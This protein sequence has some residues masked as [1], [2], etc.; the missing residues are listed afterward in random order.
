MFISPFT[1]LQAAT[2]LQLLFST[3]VQQGRNRLII[4]GLSANAMKQYYAK[5]NEAGMDDYIVNPLKQKV[6]EDLIANIYPKT[7]CS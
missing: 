5:A 1:P 7:A 3:G 4:C 6:L 2:F